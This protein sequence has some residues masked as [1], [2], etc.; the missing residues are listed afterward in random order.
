N[1]LPWEIRTNPRS[2]M[3]VQ[4][5]DLRTHTPGH[6][7]LARL[8]EGGVGGQFWSVYIPADVGDTSFARVQL[9]QIDIARQVI[10]KYPEL[11]PAGTAAEVERAMK[12]GKVASLLGV[13]GGHAIENSLGVLRTYYDLGARYMTLTH[14]RTLDWADAAGDERTH[15][16][17]TEFGREVVREMNRL[18]M[19][20]DL[21]HVSQ[22]TMSDAL[23]ETKAP[24]I[25]SHSSARAVT[26]VPRNVPDSILTRV[27]ANGGVV[28][29]TFVSGFVSQRLLDASAQH[30][31]AFEQ[32]LAAATDD[33]A[34]ARVRREFAAK[35]PPVTL[36]DVA[37]HI[38]HIRKVAGV[39]HVGIG[40]D[41]DGTESL[42]VGL[43]DVSRYPYLF[44][45]LIRRGWSDADLAKLANGNILR[46]MREAE[47]VAKRLQTERPASAV[48][49]SAGR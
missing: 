25:F 20:V 1:D 7:D 36:K 27:R 22:G 18:G 10:A 24:V 16:G 40:G 11:Q 3:D 39:D 49:F 23:D 46:A 21:S 32:A 47:R 17:L 26:D 31:A 35:L 6:T 8:R 34:R 28:M 30:R 29:V 5:Y 45:E 44:A 38:D 48:T 4:K 9:E 15:G 43:E 37:D 2:R 33:A 19:L 12:Q 41:F 14:S 13:E 42:P